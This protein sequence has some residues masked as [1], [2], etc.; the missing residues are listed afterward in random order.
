MKYNLGNHVNQENRG[1]DKCLLAVSVSGK[2]SEVLPRLV[3]TINLRGLLPISIIPSK[4]SAVQT[5]TVDDAY[6]R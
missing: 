4:E 1:S 3:A 5:V 6:D 2:T